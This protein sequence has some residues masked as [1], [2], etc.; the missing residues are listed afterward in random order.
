MDNNIFCEVDVER[1]RLKKK[2]KV[3]FAISTIFTIMPIWFF[4]LYRILEAVQA[5]ELTWVLMF[6]V[7][8][9]LTYGSILMTITLVNDREVLWPK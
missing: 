1:R 7:P 3:V 2:A 4:M 8:I 9:L 6:T 5:T